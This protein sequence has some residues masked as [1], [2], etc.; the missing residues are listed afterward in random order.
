MSADIL[1]I[2]I[3]VLV[4]SNFITYMLLKKATKDLGLCKSQIGWFKIATI[5]I[6]NWYDAQVRKRGMESRKR[7]RSGLT[8]N[9]HAS[10]HFNW[11]SWYGSSR[12]YTPDGI[13]H[14]DWHPM[15]Y[16]SMQ[17]DIVKKD[18]EKESE[19]PDV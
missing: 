11:L 4:T 3:T 5:D 6:Y 2:I 13:D 18:N 19:T 17:E 12:V 14:M 7:Y 16:E 8:M 1:V 10:D 9:R 15:S